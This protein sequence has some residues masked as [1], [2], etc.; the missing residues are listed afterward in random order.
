MVLLYV[1]HLRRTYEN[2]SIH[3]FHL[4]GDAR[5]NYNVFIKQI[6]DIFLRILSE[7]I[8]ATL[9]LQDIGNSWKFFVTEKFAS[10]EVNE[11]A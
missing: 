11:C 5:K 10:Y 1:K 3:W 9:I 7:H 4:Y 2:S 8:P 6:N